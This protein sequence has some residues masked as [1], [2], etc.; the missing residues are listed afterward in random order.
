MKLKGPPGAASYFQQRY[1]GFPSAL[2]KKVELERA[3]IIAQFH[4]PLRGAWESQYISLTVAAVWS[5]GSESHLKSGL[6]VLQT[7][8]MKLYNK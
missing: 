5:K 4:L 7:H 2:T 8:D 3:S 6:N 1:P